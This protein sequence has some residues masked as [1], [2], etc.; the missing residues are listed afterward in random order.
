MVFVII[1]GLVG[2]FALIALLGA[3]VEVLSRRLAR[4]R[5]N[6]PAVSP[7]PTAVVATPS[8]T[9]PSNVTSAVP[10]VAPVRNGWD[11]VD[12]RGR[13]QQLRPFADYAQLD[14]ALNGVLEAELAEANMKIANADVWHAI[15]RVQL[16]A[17]H[18]VRQTMQ[19]IAR[20]VPHRE[21][22]QQLYQRLL[23]LAERY[24]DPPPAGEWDALSHLDDDQLS[25]YGP[26]VWEFIRAICV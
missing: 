21:W 23:T 8:P 25:Y 22:Q 4:W 1:N 11:G 3:C 5:Q 10:V 15:G 17:V 24:R 20:D 2:L 19:S 7:P 12:R 6:R 9:P 18:D 13:P 16:A 14:A 26:T